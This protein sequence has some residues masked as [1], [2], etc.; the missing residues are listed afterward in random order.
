MAVRKAFIN[1][2]ASPASAKSS[3]LRIFPAESLIPSR[4]KNQRLHAQRNTQPGLRC[5]QGQRHTVKPN[6]IGMPTY[7]EFVHGVTSALAHV[8]KRHTG[9]VLIV[10]SGGPIATALGHILGTTPETTVKLNMRI[11]NSSVTEFTFNAKH[12][13]LQTFNTLAHL[14]GAEYAPWT[15]YA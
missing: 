14:D 3:Q 15:T 5:L 1:D 6:F 7:A 10:S 12:C 2:S 9:N 4:T 8:R 13:P 11:R